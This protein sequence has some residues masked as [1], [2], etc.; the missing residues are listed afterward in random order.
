MQLK[1]MGP[2]LSPS[3]AQQN[4]TIYH[5]TSPQPLPPT[6][7][8]AA[9]RLTCLQPLM[10]N[11]SLSQLTY[12][13][14]CTRRGGEHPPVQP[15][16]YPWRL[17]GDWQNGVPAA[18]LALGCAVTSFRSSWTSILIIF[19]SLLFHM[20]YYMW[21]CVHVFYFLALLL[22]TSGVVFYWQK[23]AL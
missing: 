3:L 13:L 22:S 8:R 19:A 18:R 20:F 7:S 15:L 6:A 11:P 2:G 16:A 1:P 21:M 4:T 23:G 10:A 5:R 14:T 12:L 17:Q 9:P